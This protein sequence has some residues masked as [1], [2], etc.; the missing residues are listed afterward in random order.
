M[1]DRPLLAFL[2][3][4]V[5][6]AGLVLGI[7]A[8]LLWTADEV[9]ARR[10]GL[11]PHR[12]LDGLTADGRSPLLVADSFL[13]GRHGLP[14]LLW[15]GFTAS[16]ASLG[17]ALAIYVYLVPGFAAQLVDNRFALDVVLRRILLDGL[18]VVFLVTLAAV[19]VHAARATP[20]R[21]DTRRPGRMLAADIA[22][23]VSIFFVVLM[24][25]FVI[26]ARFG[27]YFGGR[28]DS[29]L[30]AGVADFGLALRFGDIAGVYLYA[31]LLASWPMVVAAMVEA[32]RRVAGAGRLARAA[33]RVL[34]LL[35][36]PV[37]SLGL[38][39]GAV[40][41]AFA[42]AVRIAHVAGA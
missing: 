20:E 37:L 35:D 3:E 10:S 29:A 1:A 2:V 28:I 23:R 27:G 7:L 41:V 21:R 42:V 38:V 40:V 18:P 39:L 9:V 31:A 16:A 30:R 33:G 6:T 4:T 36:R 13:D 25:R 8:L 26:L 15:H 11:G 34:P 5:V 12:R 19:A 17:V 32:I 14:A 22:I 24:L